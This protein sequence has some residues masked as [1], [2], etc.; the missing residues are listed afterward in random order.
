M[1]ALSSIVS[2]ENLLWFG[3]VLVFYFFLNICLKYFVG[4][5]DKTCLYFL[6]ILDNYD[7]FNNQCF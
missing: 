3:R 4:F 1:S 5:K 2:F 6:Y 7:I